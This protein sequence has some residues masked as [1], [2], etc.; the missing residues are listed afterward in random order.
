[1]FAKF[2]DFH[3]GNFAAGCSRVPPFLGMHPVL[4]FSVC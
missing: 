4:C 1:M 2:F 3:A